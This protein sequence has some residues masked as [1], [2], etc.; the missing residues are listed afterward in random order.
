MILVAFLHYL[1]LIQMQYIASANGFMNKNVY[2]FQRHVFLLFF[3]FY[4]NDLKTAF[5]YFLYKF[6]SSIATDLREDSIFG[7]HLLWAT[8]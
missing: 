5:L 6:L 4:L 3:F 8:L 7:W 2:R 1:L